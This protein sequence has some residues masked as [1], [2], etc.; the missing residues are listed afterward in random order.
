MIREL[1]PR[2][3]SALA[4]TLNGLMLVAV[5]A[6]LV[7]TWTPEQLPYLEAA[8]F[9]AA[10]VVAQNLQV[11]QHFRQH[12]IAFN[13]A[14]IPLVLALFY[15]PPFAVILA[16]LISSLIF[17]AGRYI[18]S[19]VGP[20]KP[21]F[22][23]GMSTLGAASAVAVAEYAGLGAG[24]DPRTWLVAVL[25]VCAAGLMTTVLLSLM[26]FILN[27]W[28]SML[29]AWS[30][31]ALTFIGPIM[32]ASVGLMILIMLEATPWSAIPIVILM[33]TTIG[34]ARSYMKLRRQRQILDELNNFTQLVADSVRSNR[35]IDATLGRLREIFAAESATVWVPAEGRY[36]EIRLTSSVDD[37][38]LTDLDPVPEALQQAVI[39]SGGPTLIGPRHGSREQRAVLEAGGLRS[40]ILVPLR[41][42]DEV[43]GCLSVADRIGGEM[44]TFLPVDLQLLETVA[45]H[46]SIAVDNSRLVDQLRYDAYHD[47]LTGLPSRRRSLAAL[48]EALSITVPN[49]VVAVFMF[50][51]DSLHE[52]N[53]ALGHEAGDTALKEFA[54]RLQDHAPAASFLGRIDSDEFILQ[55]RLAST[56]EALD[57]A[58]R[59]RA[60]VQGPFEVGGVSVGLSAAVGVVTHP[61]FAADADE[62]LKRADGATRQAK[63]AADG[64]QLYHSGLESESLRRIGLAADLRKALDRGQLEVHF[65]PKVRLDRALDDPGAVIGAEALVRWPHPTFGLV[66]PEEFIPIAGSTGQLGHLTE[67]VLDEALRR[68][69]EWAG[70]DGPL[71][72]AV[73]LSPRTLADAD[74]PDKVAAL[75]ERHGVPAGRLTF[76]I[77]EDD[78]VSGE[79]LLTPALDRLHE[80]GVRLSVDD[81][82]TGYSSLAYLRRLPVQEIKIDLRFVQGMATDADDRAIVEAVLGLARHFAIDVVAE[83]IEAHQTVEQLRELH[84]EAGQGYYFSRPLP[85]DRFA[86]WLE[87]QGGGTGRA[88]LRAV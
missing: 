10:F 40:A 75:L 71:P 30:G 5:A 48:Q 53:D 39:A 6:A 60:A 38:G 42:G 3:F 73:N 25:G 84:C 19:D 41:S 57:T 76:E 34:L 79:P 80:M 23:V 88:R 87:H 49:E 8:T 13:L 43:Y 12:R 36:P 56:D 2:I 52:I 7:L 37:V 44:S 72:M 24:H 68:S 21:I 86:A 14:D 33:L 59:L 51:V 83:G 20:L 82:G 15:L 64:V 47:P 62:I 77:T 50:D 1:H 4:W 17:F 26:L 85:A 74:F 70:D 18:R 29:K 69:A 28:T 61:D 16:R 55:T 11:I 9:V 46:V 66:A 35:L 67:T 63:N 54:K 27:G 32:A 81:F 22:N 31:F 65:Q 45:A 58:R 78:V